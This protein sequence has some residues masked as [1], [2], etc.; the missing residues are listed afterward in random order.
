MFSS[1]KNLGAM[2]MAFLHDQGLLNF[3]EKVAV[4]WPEFA[5]NGKENYTVADV[6]RHDSN[7]SKL[8]KVLTYEDIQTENIKKN[9]VGAIIEK[10]APHI[11]SHGGKRIYHSNTKDLILNE[12]FRRIEPEGRTMGEYF[13]QV[14]K[15]KFGVDVYLRMDPE[16]LHKIEDLRGISTWFQLK[17]AWKRWDQGRYTTW[18]ISDM[19]CR[20]G[21]VMALDKKANKTLSK[22]NRNS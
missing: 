22:G 21:G 14:I 5:Q 2:C 10:Q 1:G 9:V 16:D 6:C 18:S 15:P 4:Y 20:M 7:M 12:I 11:F 8:D 19:L 17:N 13:Q 3:D